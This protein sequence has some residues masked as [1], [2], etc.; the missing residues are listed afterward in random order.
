MGYRIEPGEIEA[1]LCMNSGI[2]DAT[3]VAVHGVEN[4]SPEII[5][6]VETE[7]TTPLSQIMVTLREKL[8]T[9][10]VPHKLIKVASLPRTGNG[11]IDRQRLKAEYV[12]RS[13]PVEP[14]S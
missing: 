2:S 14:K 5:A 6:F 8:P 3:V 13:L 9:Y 11:K 10:M 4:D 7:T 12:K 1:A